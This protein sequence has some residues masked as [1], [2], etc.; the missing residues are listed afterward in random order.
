MPELQVNTYSCS[1]ENFQFTGYLKKSADML[2][3]PTPDAINNEYQDF[4]N[5]IS[6]RRSY[7]IR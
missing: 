6:G 4:I 1:P 5:I 2:D 7:N 3:N